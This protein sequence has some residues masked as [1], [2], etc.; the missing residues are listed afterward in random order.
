MIYKTVDIAPGTRLLMCNYP[1]SKTFNGSVQMTLPLDES[2]CAVSLV[3]ALLDK[4]CAR[5]PTE[6]EKDIAL[7]M[8]YGSDMSSSVTKTGDT[9]NV[10]FSFECIDDRFA[11]DKNSII[12]SSLDLIF[13]SIFNPNFIEGRFPGENVEK[14]KRL[15]K[16]KIS[17]IEDDKIAY[18]LKRLVEEMCRSEKFSKEPYGTKEQIDSLTGDD[19][20]E[21]YKR[22]K[23]EAKIDIALFGIIDEEKIINTVKDRFAYRRSSAEDISLMNTEIVEKADNVRT[24]REKQDIT[25]AKLTMG[26]R[27]GTETPGE[28][29]FALTL[30]TDIFGGNVYSK[31]FLNVREK[32]SLCYY[33][34]ARLNAVKGIIL[35]NSGVE[36][37]NIEKATES[38][39]KEFADM[40]QGNFDDEVIEQSKMF[41]SDRLKA[42]ADTPESLE[43]WYLPQMLRDEIY[44]PEEYAEKLNAVTREDII[45]AAKKVTFDTVFIL[46][47]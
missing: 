33:C 18:S 47:S 30:M 40:Q 7:D 1:G 34:S 26:L 10:K 14:E 19:L 11:L 4:T 8:L 41:Y 25:Q 32:Q 22:L 16:E 2:S 28:N 13:E 9:V 20:L 42:V 35:I 15:L 37:E 21:A 27:C 38:I 31:L 17:R 36:K 46:E 24:V 29:H 12:L 5:Y 3:A 6:R 43:N 23:D 44:T 39:K 45:A